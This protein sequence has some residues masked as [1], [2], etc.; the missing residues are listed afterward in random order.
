MNG[1]AHSPS[2]T[3][4]SRRAIISLQ[5][6]GSERR[7]STRAL[8]PMFPPQLP[9][10]DRIGPEDLDKLFGDERYHLA[11]SQE[12]IIRDVHRGRVGVELY[13]LLIVLVALV[14]GLEHVLANRFY[15]R[16]TKVAMERARPA[17]LDVSAASQARH[18]MVHPR[19]SNETSRAAAPRPRSTPGCRI[20]LQS[21]D[22]SVIRPSSFILPPL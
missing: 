11:R 17:S 8:A 21:G 22:G 2:R 1:R 19:R 4:D 6:G 3:T 20:S 7:R 18:A 12:E 16:D 10:L 15:R 13:P 5:A 9:R 14:L